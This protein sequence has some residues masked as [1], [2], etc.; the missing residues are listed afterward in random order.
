MQKQFQEEEQK[1]TVGGKRKFA[2]L[3]QQRETKSGKAQR[4]AWG[5]CLANAVK[6]C[7][8][9]KPPLISSFTDMPL[10]DGHFMVF[11]E[12]H[13]ELNPIWLVLLD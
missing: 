6:S 13:N 11:P 9:T 12:F 2:S 1:S 3:L 5:A 4:E 8:D 10:V 7:Q